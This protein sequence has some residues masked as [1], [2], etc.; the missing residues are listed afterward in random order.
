MSATVKLS[1]AKLHE[2][3]QCLSL[4]AAK[5]SQLTPV[6]LSLKKDILTMTCL[7]GCVIQYSLNVESTGNEEFVFMFYDVTPII[8]LTGDAEIEIDNYEVQ[9][10]GDSFKCAFPRGYGEPETYDFSQCSYTAIEHKDFSTGLKTI[11]GMNLDKF[12]GQAVPVNIYG[13]IAVIKHACCY[14]QA[15]AWGLPFTAQLD[16]DHVKMLIKFQPLEVSTS[17]ADTIVFRRKNSIMQ[18]PCRYEI[19][20]NNFTEF[21]KGMESKCRVT[22][23]GLHDRVREAAKVSNKSKCEILGTRAGLQVTITIENASSSLSVGD[24]NGDIQF[25]CMFHIQVFLAILK[26][27]GSGEIEILTGGDLVCLRTQTLIVLIRVEY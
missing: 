8:P 10:K 9:V 15:R 4:V 11:L 18:L 22:L 20:K 1:S 26:A 23:G 16:P 24:M 17:I 3:F 27:L 14:V 25:V 2:C 12:Y 13:D 19:P 21:L 6:S 5:G 7:Q